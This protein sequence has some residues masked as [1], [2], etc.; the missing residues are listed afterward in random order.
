MKMI[1]NVSDWLSYTGGAL[2]KVLI[3]Q[4]QL[5][6]YKQK[7]QATS[8]SNLSYRPSRVVFITSIVQIPPLLI[9]KISRC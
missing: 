3:Q 6:M 5:Y 8:S 9:P 4:A 2:I 7:G 1:G